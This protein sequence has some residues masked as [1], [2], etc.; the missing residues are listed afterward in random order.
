MEGTH[1]QSAVEDTDMHHI[2]ENVHSEY[3]RNKKERKI[4]NKKRKSETERTHCCIVKLLIS[5]N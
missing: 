2:K 4:K 1:V 5:Y 3:L